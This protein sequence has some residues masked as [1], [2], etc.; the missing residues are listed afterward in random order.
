MKSAVNL[1]LG[2]MAVI[3]VCLVAGGYPLAAARTADPLHGDG[4]VLSARKIAGGQSLLVQ[5]DADSLQPPATRIQLHFEQRSFR[6]HPHPGRPQTTYFAIIGIPYRSTPGPDFITLD[7]SNV[8]GRHT[9]KLPVTIVSGK[10]KTDVL[11]VAASRVTPNRKNIQR[12]KKEARR[13]KRI[14]ASAGSARL[15]RGPFR[16]PLKSQI[17]SAFG[18]RRVFNGQLKSYHNGVDFRAAVGTPVFAANSGVVRLAQNLF[19]SG[20]VV[21][22]DHG[23]DIFTIYAHL[24]KIEVRAGQFIAGGQRLGLSGATGRVSGP[25]LHWGV[26]VNGVAVDPI[27]FIRTV[28]LLLA[29]K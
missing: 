29:T 1:P 12:A 27:Q 9:R 3:L 7:W 17:T 8:Q 28:T 13:L 14:Y 26:K 10:Y 23:T 4:I 6:L 18:N 11:K 20:N 24:D 21:V 19:Y 25:H 22:I 2:L 16:P 5:V 15:W